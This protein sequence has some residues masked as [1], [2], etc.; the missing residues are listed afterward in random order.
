MYIEQVLSIV[1]N[2]HYMLSYLITQKPLMGLCSINVGNCLSCLFFYCLENTV[3]G[4]S[5]WNNR[6]KNHGH[7]FPIWWGNGSC[8]WFTWCWSAWHWICKIFWT[9]RNRRIDHVAVQS[10][11]SA[12]VQVKEHLSLI[13]GLEVNLFP[14]RVIF[15][16]NQGT[17]YAKTV[18]ESIKG[19]LW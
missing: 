5:V 1:F 16:A 8:E 6:W 19:E 4:R 11:D 3:K 17:L 10:S 18:K 14:S 13:L 7:N 2:F 9:G 15:R 12:G